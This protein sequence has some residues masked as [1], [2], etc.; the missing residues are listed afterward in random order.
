MEEVD[1]FRYLGVDIDT[2]SEIY[3]R[4]IDDYEGKWLAFCYYQRLC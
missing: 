2:Q 4:F 3:D 1:C